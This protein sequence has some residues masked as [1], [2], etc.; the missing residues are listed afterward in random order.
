MSNICRFGDRRPCAAAGSALLATPLLRPVPFR[1]PLP[2]NRRP[3]GATLFPLGLLL[4]ALSAAAA[5]YKPGSDAQVLER[6]SAR[7]SD[8]RS[9]DIESLREAWQRDPRN[10]DTAVRLARRLFDEA[11]AQGDPRYVGHAQAVLG[12][13]WSEPA[14]PVAVRVQRAKLLQYG[15]RFDEALADLAAVVEADTGNAEAWAN[16]AAIRMVRADYAG[17]RRDCQAL[18]PLT[19]PLIAVA[20][21]AYADSMSGKIDEAARAIEGALAAAPADTAAA[22]RLWVLTRQAEIEVRRGS[23]VAAEAAFR[24]A[25]ALGLPDVYLLAA[26]ADFLLDRGRAAD[27]LKLLTTPRGGAQ[28]A[29]RADVLLLRMALAARATNDARAAA[30]TRELGARFEA[31]RARGDTTHEKEESRFALALQGDA[32]RA[33]ALARSN[34]ELQREPADARALLDAALAARD[35]AAAE[36]AL[37][38]L[39]DN[40]VQDVTLRRLERSLGAIK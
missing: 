4:A 19:T 10:P 20:C 16:A 33:L 6:V 38:W 30:W 3:T 40:G 28:E 22:E 18:A 35:V 32:P 12:P 25:L 36:P 39:R 2:R 23:D 13:W 37:K 34:F 5:P 11:L 17:A 27:A 14:P 21:A 15:H 31:A 24:A 29:S 1:A 8:P 9:R 26:Y 7:A